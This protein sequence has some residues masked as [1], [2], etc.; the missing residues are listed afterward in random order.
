MTPIQ[1]MTSLYARLEDND[2]P[3]NLGALFNEPILRSIVSNWYAYMKYSDLRYKL[4]F[5]WGKNN[6]NDE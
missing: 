1:I 6:T 4:V 3:C 2:A 5:Y